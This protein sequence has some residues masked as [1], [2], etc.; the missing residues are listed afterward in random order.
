M[1]EKMKQVS[2]CLVIVLAIIAAVTATGFIA[3]YSMQAWIVAYWVTLTMKNVI[4]YISLR[5]AEKKDE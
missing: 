1:K 2:A 5:K 3:G 4:D